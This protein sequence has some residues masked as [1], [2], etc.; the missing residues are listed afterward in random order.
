MQQQLEDMKEQ[1]ADEKFDHDKTRQAS[2]SHV[3]ALEAELAA[4]K[5][6]GAVASGGGEETQYALMVSK[7]RSELVTAEVHVIPSPMPPCID[8]L[9]HC[10]VSTVLTGLHSLCT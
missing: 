2:L 1:L 7:L 9:F 5:S 6:N 4:L 8:D 10:C 3:E